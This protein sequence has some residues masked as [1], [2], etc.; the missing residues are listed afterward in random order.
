MSVQ[1]DGRIITPGKL[2]TLPAKLGQQLTTHFS[3]ANVVFPVEERWQA[4]WMRQATERPQLGACQTRNEIVYV[5]YLFALPLVLSMCG[6]TAGPR[7]RRRQTNFW[8]VGS[9]T[10]AGSKTS[11]AVSPLPEISFVPSALK[12]GPCSI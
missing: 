12:R 9:G 8:K 5:G 6:W 4:C 3:A 11:A 10:L 2:P 1:A 7:R